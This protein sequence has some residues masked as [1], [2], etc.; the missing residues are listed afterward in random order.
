MN[1]VSF[2]PE[3]TDLSSRRLASDLR[4]SIVRSLGAGESVVIDLHRVES[5]SESYADE[6]FGMLA[7]GLGI[8][9]FLQRVA[10]V[11]ANQH[12][13]RVVAHALKER[14]EQESGKTVRSQIQAL[15]AAKHAQRANF[16]HC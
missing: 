2:A 9:E 6:L 4:S 13:L 16:R 8:K 5:I 3:N 7:I 14:L 11:H 15:V 12:V 1:R 10:V